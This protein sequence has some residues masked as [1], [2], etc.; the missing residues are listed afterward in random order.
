GTSA[1]RTQGD[2]I[3]EVLALI[4]ARPIWDDASRRVTGFE[5]VPIDVLGRPR[6]DVTLRISGFFRDSFPHVITLLD[7]AITAVAALD[8]PAEVN[9]VRAH[10]QADLTRHGDER[11]ATTRIFGSKPG[12][13]GAGVLALVD[14]P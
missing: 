11:R 9:Y 8:E 12:A 7:D 5:I 13:Y 4:G 6:I 10:A 3:A 2:D 14:A 1:M